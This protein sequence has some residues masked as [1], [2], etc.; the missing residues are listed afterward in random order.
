M[1]PSNGRLKRRPLGSA[2]SFGRVPPLRRYY[3]TLRLPAARL[4]ALR[5]LRLAIPSFRPAFVPVG[6]GRG[7]RI[8][9]ELVSR[10]SNRHSDGGGRVSQVPERPSCP[11]ALFYAPGRTEA[12]Q[13]V[14]ACRRGPRLC[15]PR[16]L[17]RRED[18]GARSHGMGTRCLGFAGEGYPS[19]APDSLPAAGQ[20]LPSGIRS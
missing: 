5:C 4:A 1:F 10:V 6:L 13:A 20:A 15:Q 8:I 14:A 3:G 12:R 11:F 18:F 19:A 17:P 9:L 7:P 2:G 16:W